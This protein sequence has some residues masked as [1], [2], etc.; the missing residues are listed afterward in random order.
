MLPYLVQL[1]DSGLIF[2]HSDRYSRQLREF[3][4][5][6][7]SMCTTLYLPFV[8]YKLFGDNMASYSVV[9]NAIIVKK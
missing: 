3:K 5:S 4:I 7:T 2:N 8:L 9:K 6:V 1:I